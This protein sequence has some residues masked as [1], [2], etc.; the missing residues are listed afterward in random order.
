VTIVLALS[1]Q[2][3]V[4]GQCADSTP[5]GLLQLKGSP[6]FLDETAIKIS[7]DIATFKLYTSADASDPGTDATLNCV[8]REFSVRDGE[9]WS[10]PYRVLAGE[11]LYPIGKKLCDW[12]AKGFLQRFSF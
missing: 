2:L 5:A 4:T 7:N 11:S 6:Y 3:P 8:S 12:D 1:L 9:Q 10:T